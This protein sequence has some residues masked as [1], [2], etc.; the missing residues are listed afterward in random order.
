[1][2]KETIVQT[3]GVLVAVATV[4]MTVAALIAVITGFE[5]V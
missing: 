1:M 4:V 3:I 5:P 2:T